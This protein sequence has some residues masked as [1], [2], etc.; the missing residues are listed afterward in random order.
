MIHQLSKHNLQE[1]SKN[2][3]GACFIPAIVNGVTN[4]HLVSEI[5]SKYSDSVSNLINNLRETINVHNQ[6]K[7]SLS[8]KKHRIILIGDSNIKGYVADAIG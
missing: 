4:V 3:D 6:E 8:K 2:E 5:E 1:P 7:C